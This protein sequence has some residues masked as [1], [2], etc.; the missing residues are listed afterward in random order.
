MERERGVD[1]PA[2]PFDDLAFVPKPS[3]KAVLALSCLIML[4]QTL[5]GARFVHRRGETGLESL[6]RN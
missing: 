6:R 3:T 2:V 4:V 1:K 5:L